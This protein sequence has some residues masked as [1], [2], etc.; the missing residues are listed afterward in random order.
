MQMDANNN[1]RIK[2][3]TIVILLAIL[4][5]FSAVFLYIQPFKSYYSYRKMLKPEVLA[6]TWVYS[7]NLNEYV[8]IT[9]RHPTKEE[10]IKFN[11][12]MENLNKDFAL[13]G[14][15]VGHYFREKL[16]YLKLTADSIRIKKPIKLSYGKSYLD[17]LLNG[18]AL[19]FSHAKDIGT[20]ENC[21]YVGI[22]I[23]RN[24]Q[25]LNNDTLELELHQL[26]WQ[27]SASFNLNN[28]STY[29]SYCSFTP[30]N[31]HLEVLC[32]VNSHEVINTGFYDSLKFELVDFIDKTNADSIYFSILINPERND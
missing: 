20:D 22:S 29:K 14:Y 11:P 13:L 7:L 16:F 18:N 32:E 15:S 24:G 26:I 4:V 31:K 1:K 21:H 25:L 9:T 10:L 30:S 19:I 2:R 23:L 3:N 6:L 12:K 8:N 27:H 28:K 5:L 17:F